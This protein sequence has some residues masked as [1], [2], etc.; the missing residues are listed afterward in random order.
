MFALVFALHLAGLVLMSVVKFP[1]RNVSEN[2]VA[3]QLAEGLGPEPP[4][5]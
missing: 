4:H 2:Q 1:R 5:N 3:V